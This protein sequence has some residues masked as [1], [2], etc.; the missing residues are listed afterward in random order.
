[1]AGPSI[2]MYVSYMNCCKRMNIVIFLKV[3]IEGQCSKG[4]NFV[5]W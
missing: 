2:K 3:N 4:E 1:V 5:V